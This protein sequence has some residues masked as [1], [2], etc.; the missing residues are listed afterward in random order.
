MVVVSLSG[1]QTA[2]GPPRRGGAHRPHPAIFLSVVFPVTARAGPS[3]T[4]S[5]RLSDLDRVAV[6]AGGA[7]Q[8]GLGVDARRD[9]VAYDREQPL[10]DLARPS[11][12][13]S[14]PARVARMISLADSASAGWVSGTPSAAE[15]RPFSAIFCRSH[16]SFS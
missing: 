4:E 16:V 2:T 14:S 8:G 1:D 7:A 5:G 3:R 6:G 13:A 10:A 11:G 9:G 15:V 12:A